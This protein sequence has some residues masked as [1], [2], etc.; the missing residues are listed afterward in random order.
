MQAVTVILLAAITTG[1][2]VSDSPPYPPPGRLIDIG[3]WRL[4]LNCTCDVRPGQSTDILEAGVGDFSV[5][6]SLVEAGVDDPWRIMPDGKLVR[7]ST[8]LTTRP[9]PSDWPGAPGGVRHSR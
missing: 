2:S 9:I 4:H 7:S 6:W 1:Q 8:L 5:E 3:G